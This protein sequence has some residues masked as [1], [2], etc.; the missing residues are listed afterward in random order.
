MCALVVYDA[1][2]RLPTRL[3]FHAT[4]VVAA[5]AAT[6][7]T[8]RGDLSSSALAL[9]GAAASS[10]LTAPPPT[11]ATWTLR[12]GSPPLPP[13]I[14]PLVFPVA[15]VPFPSVGQRPCWGDGTAASLL[16]LPLLL[17]LLL[18]LLNFILLPPPPPFP[19]FA[20]GAGVVAGST[21]GVL[22]APLAVVAVDARLH[23]T[24]VLE[25]P[26]VRPAT[27]AVPRK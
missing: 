8:G 12:A 23:V 1:T 25:S 13:P 24:D 9:E 10:L 11:P 22:W 16:L 2:P 3:K 5:E 27:K 6:A 21:S 14:P 26:P 19:P 15:P 4:S 7:F 20:N 18:L 17:L